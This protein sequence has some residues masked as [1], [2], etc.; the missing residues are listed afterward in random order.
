MSILCESEQFERHD[1]QLRPVAVA[2][3]WHWHFVAFISRWIDVD[4]SDARIR[5]L[6]IKVSIYGSFHLCRFDYQLRRGAVEEIFL[7][8]SMKVS[9]FYFNGLRLMELSW[10]LAALCILSGSE[11]GIGDVRDM[12]SQS[13][14]DPCPLEEG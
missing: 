2:F 4:S 10:K 8:Y 14:G 12:A 5:D 1:V 3:V 7:M 11:Q 13:G 6:S 9:H